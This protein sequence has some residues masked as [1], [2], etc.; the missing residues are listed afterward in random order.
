EDLGGRLVLVPLAERAEAR[1]GLALRVALEV[2]RPLRPLVCDDHPAPDDRV[3][4]Q[5]GHARTPCQVGYRYGQ[6]RFVAR[7]GLVQTGHMIRSKSGDGTESS[8]IPSRGA[9]SRLASSASSST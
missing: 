5:L 7:P 8:K 1:L 2:V 3:L 6:D 4:T 9:R